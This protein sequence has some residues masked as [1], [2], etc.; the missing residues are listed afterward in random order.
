M[1]SQVGSLFFWG[2]KK[3][4]IAWNK[5]DSLF[6]GLWP[7]RVHSYRDKKF[8]NKE[9]HLFCWRCIGT[10]WSM[11][12][13]TR[14]KDSDTKKFLT[15][16]HAPSFTLPLKMLCWNSSG[17]EVWGAQV[18][19][20]LAWPCNKLFP[21][22][23]SDVYVLFGLTAL[24]TWGCVWQQPGLRDPGNIC[25]FWERSE[26]VR[27]ILVRIFVK[28]HGCRCLAQPWTGMRVGG[29]EA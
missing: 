12:I 7:L 9:W 15:I 10:L 28:T 5:Q 1:L 20:L 4:P 14:T 16:N 27:I 19:C 21:A 24:D 17:M 8:Q 13:A 18:T 25:S 29:G 11:W 22:L 2:K 26:T 6:S 23:N 3:L